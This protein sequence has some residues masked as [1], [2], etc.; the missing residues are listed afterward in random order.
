[1]RK[2][3]CWVPG[4]SSKVRLSAGEPMK[5]RSRFLASS[6]ENNAPALDS[7]LAVEEGEDAV[8]LMNREYPSHAGVVIES[9]AA[10]IGGGVEIVHVGIRMSHKASITEDDPGL[11]WGSDETIP[12]NL[13]NGRDR[14]TGGGLGPSALRQQDAACDQRTRQQHGK[15]QNYDRPGR[16][17]GAGLLLLLFLFSAFRCEGRAGLL[18]AAFRS[19]QVE[20]ERVGA[21]G[22][23]NQDGIVG[24]LVSVALGQLHA[25]ASSLNADRGVA[26]GI[27][28]RRTAQN[29]SSFGWRSAF[30]AAI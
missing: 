16:G 9:H 27:G 22:E 21:F 25:K 14:L 2:T 28:S 13:I 7:H 17:P 4:I 3:N 11:L 18:E 15:D 1:L 24:P 19:M 12:K 23:F 6:S 5:I 26:L 29:L 10:G 20:G 8:E 30:S